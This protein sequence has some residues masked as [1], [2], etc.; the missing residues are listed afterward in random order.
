MCLK[1]STIFQYP[2]PTRL[3]L[4]AQ[5]EEAGEPSMRTV[6]ERACTNWM[7][8]YEL[9]EEPMNKTCDAEG[10]AGEV[11]EPGYEI[12]RVEKTRNV[13]PMCEDYAKRQGSKPVAVMCCEG[14]CLRGEVARQ[15]ANILC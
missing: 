4:Y 8:M 3:R 5:R 1:K 9:G 2:F 15:A 11:A 10:K 12:V 13:C 14:T 6:T 7:P